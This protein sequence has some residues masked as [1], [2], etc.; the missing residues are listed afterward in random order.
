MKKI[1]IVYPQWQGAD[2]ARWIPNIP[3]EDASRGY[4]LG[5]MLLN[6]LAPKTDCETFTVPVSTGY[7]ERLVTDGILDKETLIK[8]TKAALDV[9]EIAKPDKVVTLGGECSVSVPVFTWLN[10]KYGSDL[11]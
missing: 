6:W 10:A 4:Y 7:S 8:Q 11:Q 1:R 9:L 3:E 5:A 2:I